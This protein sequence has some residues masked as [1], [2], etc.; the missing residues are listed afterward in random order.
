MLSK[1]VPLKSLCIYTVTHPSFS[2][3]LVATVCSLCSWHIF[4][5]DIYPSSLPLPG[6]LFSTWRLQEDLS[7][8]VGTQRL[9]CFLNPDC[10][11]WM[12]A[13]CLVCMTPQLARWYQ[14]GTGI[15]TPEAASWKE[16]AEYHRHKS[17]Q[18]FKPWNLF[19]ERRRLN[20][21]PW[22]MDLPCTRKQECANPD[23]SHFWQVAFWVP[24]QFFLQ[25]PTEEACMALLKKWGRKSVKALHI[26]SASC[27]FVPIRN[28]MYTG[29]TAVPLSAIASEDA[30]LTRHR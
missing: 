4:T 2:W 29:A 14:Q 30:L 5:L 21:I 23:A 3:T 9:F 13:L 17:E 16:T 28:W 20:L 6:E 10:G 1:C 26:I 25:T 22:E 19:L 12:V 27:V 8:S 18:E 24:T 11:S 7:R 15:V